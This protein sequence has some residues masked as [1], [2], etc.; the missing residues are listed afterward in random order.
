MTMVTFIKTRVFYLQYDW[1]KGCAAALS[2][3]LEIDVVLAVTN[4]P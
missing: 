2:H 3:Q 4:Q 1:T